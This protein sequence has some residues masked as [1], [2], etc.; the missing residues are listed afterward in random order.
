MCCYNTWMYF[1]KL[2]MMGLFKQTIGQNISSQILTCLINYF[3]ICPAKEPVFVPTWP[4]DQISF[5]DIFL[6][7]YLI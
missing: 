4:D 7:I 3:F 1:Q 2:I 5:N 6:F